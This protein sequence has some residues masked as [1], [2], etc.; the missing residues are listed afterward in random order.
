MGLVTVAG[1][2]DEQPQWR[3]GLDAVGHVAHEAVEP[4]DADVE[5]WPERRRLRAELDVAS[6]GLLAY[7]GPVNPRPDDQ[8]DWLL[9]P[10]AQLDELF[11]AAL[12]VVAV[13]AGDHHHGD[14]AR[15]L[16]PASLD[17]RA[18]P[19]PVVDIVGREHRLA[20]DR[21]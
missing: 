2:H 13:P 1:T 11:Q 6:L 18:R 15:V 4:A 8:M 20:E 5:V 12:N 16:V 9:Q 17:Q 7:A 3:I 21:L 14:V 19:V 10:R